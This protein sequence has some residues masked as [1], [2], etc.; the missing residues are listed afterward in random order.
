MQGS[1]GADCFPIQIPSL[2]THSLQSF[3]RHSQRELILSLQAR[4]PDA[5]KYF[6]SHFSSSCEQL[7]S[8]NF[9]THKPQIRE[10]EEGCVR[11]RKGEAEKK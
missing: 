2:G 1:K 9:S 5:L 4:R 10:T 3:H 8:E 11:W 6:P 7:H